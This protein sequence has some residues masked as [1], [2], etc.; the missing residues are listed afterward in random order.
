MAVVPKTLGKYQILEPV[1]KGGMGEVY[2][3]YQP[4]LHRHVAIK[5]L[6][7]GGHASEDFI[8][9]F[10]Q[11]ARMAAK[12]VHP[13][14]VQI[15]DI[16]EEG[17]LPY[18]VMEF[19]E[20]RSLREILAEKGRLDLETAL[21]IAHSV[22][23]A[24]RFA[25]EHRIIHRDIKPANLLLDRQGRVRILDFGLAKSLAEG[26]AL[27]AS[28]SMVGT[29]YY[30]SP[31]QAF[32][33]P[34]EVDGRTDLF[35]LGAVL[36]E[37]L[38]GR[39][40]F[41][42]GTILAV[43]RKIEEEDPAP[44]GVSPA[45]D[46][47]ILRA[48][49]K[50]R[51]RRFPTAQEMADALLS[52]LKGPAPAPTGRATWAAEP[53]VLRLP[54]RIVWAA[55]T[56]VAALLVGSLVWAVWPRPPEPEPAML[57]K[58]S[59][60]FVNM[61]ADLATELRALLARKNDVLSG[62]LVRYRDDPALRRIIAE[63]FIERGQFSRALD[64]LKGYERVIHEL[65]S[66]KGLQRFVSP[67]LFRLTIA[68]PRD[69]KGAEAFL[70]ESILRHLE[71]KQ[72]AAR[73][74]LRAAENQG[75]LPSHVLLIR[76]HLDLW[77]VWPNPEGDA[78]RPVLAAL[79][80][81]L[82]RS[83][84]LFLLPLRAVAAHLAGERELAHEIAERLARRSGSSAES[85]LLSSI[86]LQREGQIELAAAELRDAHRMDPNPRHFDDSIQRCWLRLLEVLNDPAGEKL[87]IDP[88]SEK[89]DVDKM[90]AEEL[91][92]ALDERLRSDHYPAALLLRAALSAAESKWPDAE[93]DLERLRKR[94]VDPARATV[95]HERLAGF[96]AATGSRPRL[97][98]AAC[99]L[100]ILL[101]RPAQAFAT[102]S[103]LLAE[104]PPEPE[105]LL[106]T[107]VR[108]ARLASADAPRALRHLELALGLGAL[109]AELRNDESLG[110]V[111]GTPAFQGLLEAHLGNHVAEAKR[112]LD[113]EAQALHHLE[114]A[115]KLGATPAE[116]RGDAEL[117]PFRQRPAFEELLRRYED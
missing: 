66:A 22:C 111:R 46:A 61:P 53:L 104:E 89:F 48:L 16:A 68:Q 34:E 74:K 79:R 15:H 71:G 105:L 27:T 10:Q 49:A 98:D 102:A 95:D 90:Y 110:D 18:I 84:E 80:R 1:G 47:L 57:T 101:G 94:L 75:A 20:G 39:P 21:R 6:L 116:L 17:G 88:A 108:I 33:A 25:H 92:E 5:T 96:L 87:W 86:L 78:E 67:G 12:L 97:L 4:D 81:E 117:G 51:D 50:D 36:Y 99:D 32:A 62:E 29:P 30:M 60:S 8:R 83:D 114:E 54:R 77:D 107:H 43:L 3:A 24:L 7:A 31:E 85:F 38:V 19:V 113:D 59:G 76:A 45:V 41:E 100:Q 9:R 56:A 65:A 106:R 82:D 70:M 55:G 11:E 91:R 115:L 42:G 52:C 37:M 112:R 13:N 35:S 28:G 69:L 2:R 73:L 93:A 109:P 72:A 40:P 58:L 103:L 44:P 23:R 14:I 63:H 64:Y 26:K